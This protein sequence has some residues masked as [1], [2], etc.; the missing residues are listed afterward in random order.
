MTVCAVNGCDNPKPGARG[1][2]GAHY[3]RL[4]LHGDPLVG[5][6]LKA[7]PGEGRAWLERHATFCE[8]ECVEWP[9]AKLQGGYGTLIIEGRRTTAHRLMCIMAHGAPADD[10]M[11]AAHSCNNRACCNPTHLRWATVRENHADKIGHGTHMRGEKSIRA[12]ITRAQA[13]AI[14]RDCKSHRAAEVAKLHNVSKSTV[15]SI[16]YGCSWSW[17]TDQQRGGCRVNSQ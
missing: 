9:F 14:W 5:G 12:R 1:Y 17:L 16:Q 11:H 7:S 2:C 6:D 8:A 3:R 15:T 13:L 10:A 4:R